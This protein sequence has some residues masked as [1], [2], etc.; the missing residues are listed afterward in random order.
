MKSLWRNPEFNLL[1]TSQSLSYLGDG[2]ATLALSLLVLVETGSPIYAGLVGTITQVARLVLRLPAGVL[3]DRLD[4]RRVMM[5]CDALRLA[6]FTTLTVAVVSGR[7]GF[8]LILMV[9]AVDAASS[10][11]SGT[12][13]DASVRSIVPIAQLPSA[14][15]RN[16]ARSHGASLAGPPLGGL[17]FGLGHAIPFL[18]NAISCLV[19]IVLVLF[20][21]KPLQ[22][23][24]EEEPQTYRAALVEGIRFVFTNPFLRALML[25]AAPLNFAIG[26]VLFTLIVALQRNGTPPAAIGLTETI[27]AAGGLLGAF[28]APA[29][30]GRLGL[31]A[32]TRLICWAAAALLASVSILTSTVAAAVPLGLAVFLGPACNA[33]L[34]GF[35]A[36]ITPDRLQGR[37]ISVIMVA[38]TSMAAAAPIVAGLLLAS[39]G[40]RAAVLFFAAAVVGSALVATLGNGI[41]RAQESELAKAMRVETA[42]AVQ[43]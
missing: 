24:R 29:L 23:E 28:V 7:A 16:E 2:I 12:A 25:I 22:G 1:W 6:A 26:G 40:A 35:Q 42:S 33:A 36:A 21:R 38:A 8:A 9:A 39:V 41:R 17:L 37:V 31:L 4:R 20:I 32:L 5:S 11:V 30:Q 15:A 43:N 27:V 14:V 13:E 34:F 10:A 19:S 18:T 3:V